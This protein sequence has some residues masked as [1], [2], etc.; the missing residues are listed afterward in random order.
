MIDG[1]GSPADKRAL[2][3]PLAAEVERSLLAAAAAAP[4]D[5]PA[6]QCYAD[7][8]AASGPFRPAD[9]AADERLLEETRTG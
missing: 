7:L 2:A 6:A 4:A 3:E 9:V 1:P 8:T 5:E